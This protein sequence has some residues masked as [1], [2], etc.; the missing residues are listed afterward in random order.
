MFNILSDRDNAKLKGH[1]DST[2]HQ[3]EWLIS[4]TQV[5]AKAGKDLENEEHSSIAGGIANWYNHSG[6]Q[7]GG[8]SENWK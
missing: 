5:T 6:N 4:K 3:S 1:R 8:S 2:L 7:S